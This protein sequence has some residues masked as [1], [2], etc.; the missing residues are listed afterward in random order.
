MEEKIEIGF[1]VDCLI[2]MRD[3][4]I[5]NFLRVFSADEFSAYE[6]GRSDLFNELIELLEFENRKI[7]DEDIKTD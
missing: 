1:C 3:D 6:K 2:K 5:A 4:Y 7:Q